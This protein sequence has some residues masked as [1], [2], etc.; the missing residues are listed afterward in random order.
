M[1]NPYNKYDTITL[2]AVAAG[3]PEELR[4]PFVWL[5]TFIREECNRDLDLLVE[6]AQKLGIGTDKTNWSKLIRGHWNKDADGNPTPS[7]AVALPRLL[8]NIETIRKDSRIKS[9]SGKIPF[10]V[11][12]TA[13]SIFNY[14]DLKRSPDRVCKFGVVIGETGS[15]K[16]ASFRQYCQHN[17]HGACV[18]VESPETPSMRQF[19]T[20][21]ASRYGCGV[22]AS[23]ERKKFTILRAVNDR[24]CIIVDNVQRLYIERMEGNQPIFNFL[25]KIQ[26][27]TGC[28]VILSFTPTFE[29]RFT[30]GL[31][32]GFFEQF[33]G[34]SGGRRNFL[35][36]PEYAP[37]EDVLAI[38]QAFGLREAE[39]HAD[40]L[41]KIAREPGRIRRL[42]EDLQNAKILAV[43]RKTQLAMNHV[44]QA[45]DEEE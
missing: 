7:P 31:N 40:E 15:Q 5:G 21:L 33:E 2:E 25:Q 45:R 35:R 19:L 23:H 17:N 27:D 28:T 29:R 8:R 1:D 38:A 42:F 3:Y 20:D 39:K 36:L 11:T 44:R 14:I 32:A 43:R 4:E 24:K 41:V 30:A 13:A 9:Q 26:E 18:W 22:S 12:P 6:R 34:R 10:V 37:E 16:T